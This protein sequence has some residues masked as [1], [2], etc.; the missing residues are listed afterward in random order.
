MIFNEESFRAEAVKFAAYIL[1]ESARTAP[2]GKGDDVLDIVF[3]NGYEVEKLCKEMEK[4]AEE[5][6]NHV[7]RRDANSIR[8][9]EGVLI[10]GVDV[11]KSLGLNCG[12]CGYKTCADFQKALQE[13]IEKGENVLP[14][15]FKVMDLG[16]A[17][18]SAAK[19]AAIFGLD[20]RVMYTAGMAA[21][22]LG[23]VKGDIVLT[24]PLAALGKNPF[25]DRKD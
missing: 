6:N 21:K 20:N 18:G 15:V 5:R 25:F 1:A 19:L 9:A 3:I 13:R 12:Y 4:I 23:Y 17:I 24:I 2:K 7:F 16:I 10:I 11:K 8:K 22:R 14:C